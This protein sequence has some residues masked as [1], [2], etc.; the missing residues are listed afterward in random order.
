VTKQRVLRAEELL[1]QTDRSVEWIASEV[2]FGNAATFRHHFTRARGVSPQ[3]YRRAF[4]EVAD[5]TA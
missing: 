2:G 1:E 5:R 3:Q 4:V